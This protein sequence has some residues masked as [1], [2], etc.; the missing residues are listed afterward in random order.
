M[1]TE[2]KNRGDVLL[3]IGETLSEY[4]NVKVR[5]LN[6]SLFHK[7]KIG[8]IYCYPFYKIMFSLMHSKEIDDFI[9]REF[10]GDLRD[11]KY[12]VRFSY[13]I[14]MNIV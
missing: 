8:D 10:C 12:M 4:Y 13:N 9:K 14:L 6:N 11:W 7:N 5:V 1:Y 3:N 2:Y